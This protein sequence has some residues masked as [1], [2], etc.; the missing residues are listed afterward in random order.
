MLAGVC[1][2]GAAVALIATGVGAAAGFGVAVKTVAVVGATTAVVGGAGAAIAH[3]SEK[4]TDFGKVMEN[5]KEMRKC[6]VAIEQQQAVVKGKHGWLSAAGERDPEQEKRI[7]SDMKAE[8]TDALNKTQV[9]VDKGF[10][11]IKF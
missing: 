6:L 5:L 2:I 9:E 11:I 4:V 7:V 1:G 10:N 3:A 8:F